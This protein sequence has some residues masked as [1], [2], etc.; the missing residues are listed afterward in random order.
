MFGITS[1]EGAMIFVRR[2]NYST[3]FGAIVVLTKW[4]PIFRI[5]VTNIKYK[6]LIKTN[7]SNINKY[8]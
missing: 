2:K 5:A 4:C 1:G 7:T 3:S 6:T 8:I